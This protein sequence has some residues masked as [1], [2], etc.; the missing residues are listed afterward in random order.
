M[1]LQNV[2]V[3]TV[4]EELDGALVTVGRK[5]A[6]AAKLKELKAAVTGDESADIELASGVESAIFLSERLAQK[7]ISANHSRAVQC[8]AV[9]RC[10]VDDEQV[11]TYC[12]IAIDVAPHEKPGRIGD[13]RALLVED[14]IAEFLGLTYLGGG[15]R[16]AHFQRADPAQRPRRPVRSYRP[17]TQ[18][19]VGLQC[20]NESRHA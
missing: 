1:V 15:L 13:R 2:C 7:S 12:I 6:G 9:A 11:V 20:R 18:A 3:D 17:R 10:V 8:G 19:S 14:P 16:Q 5:R 4:P